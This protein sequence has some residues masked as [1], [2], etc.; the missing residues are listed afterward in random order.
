MSNVALCAHDTGTIR[1]DWSLVRRVVALVAM[2][3]FFVVM[4][5]S[6]L[7]PLGPILSQALRF[8]THNMGYLNGSFMVAAAGSGLLGSL[9]LDRFERRGALAIALSG[10]AVCTALAG[11]ATDLETLMACRFAAG[12][13][14]GPAMALGMAIVSDAAPP[15]ARGR[16]IGG[17]AIGSGIAIILGVPFALAM[18]EWLGWR[19]M[20]F[21]IGSVGLVLAAAAFAMLPTGLN[22][23]RQSGRPKEV[24]AEFLAMLRRAETP[25]VLGTTGLIICSTIVMAAN[26]AAYFVFNLGH[27]ESELK[28]LWMAGGVSSL[29]G[30]QSAGFFA[31]RFGPVPVLWALSALAIVTFF[32]LFVQQPPVLPLFVLFSA[33]ML[34]ANGRILLANTISSLASRSGNRGRFMSLVSAS[35]QTA[36]AAGLV[37]AS[38]ILRTDAT[39]RL[40]NM[41]YL[42]LFGIAAAL[43][44]VL[45]ATR[46]HRNFDRAAAT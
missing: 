4:E 41:D 12:L 40:I 42:A 9:Y 28:Y 1:T 29:I 30:S 16:A 34:C 6:L 26:L 22:K 25:L 43:A 44:S 24:A 7:L 32:M 23:T 37:I 21:L 11:F 36:S 8:S 3:Q 45:L 18:A 35:N 33:F 15:E 14:G 27:P 38:Q 13:C 46:L 17:V 31:D 19:A 39:G 20:F 10:V 5:G 2:V